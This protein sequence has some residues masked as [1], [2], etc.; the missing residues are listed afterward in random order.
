[1]ATRVTSPIALK[2]YRYFFW[3]FCQ[4]PKPYSN[5]N[6]QCYSLDTSWD[7]VMK[8]LVGSWLRSQRVSTTIIVIY[9]RNSWHE[10]E[11]SMQQKRNSI[12]Y[13]LELCLYWTNPSRWYNVQANKST[14]H[15]AWNVGLTS[16]QQDW[17]RSN[18]FSDLDWKMIYK[19]TH[20]WHSPQTT[21]PH[22]D[23]ITQNI[24]SSNTQSHSFFASTDRIILNSLRPSDAIWRHRSGST[25]AQVMVCC[26]TAPSHYLNQCCDLS[27]VRS[28]GIHLR[29][30]S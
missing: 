11:D 19:Y 12:A 10:I 20:T 14:T 17:R 1:M 7:F 27:S 23:I 2:F 29:A 21:K 24:D 9:M 6:F 8:R 5:S 25:L 22:S 18:N 13:K 16:I 26:L 30:I 28:S 3:I 15:K 4:I